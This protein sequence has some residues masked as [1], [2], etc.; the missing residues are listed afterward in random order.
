[1]KKLD[2]KNFDKSCVD[3]YYDK[4]I[5][6]VFDLFEET[7]DEVIVIPN[8]K[9]QTVVSSS[10][11]LNVM[12]EAGITELEME[13]FN[14]VDEDVES[15]NVVVI[16]QQLVRDKKRLELRSKI[17]NDMDQYKA[18]CKNIIMS[19]YL[20]E[21]GN[22]FYKATVKSNKLETIRVQ[23]DALYVSK[24]FDVTKW[25]MKNEKKY[26]ELALGAN[27]ILGKPTHNAFQER[28][29]SRGT[30]SDTKLRK[31]L[32]E[33]YFE[34]SVLNS[35]NGKHIDDI[36]HMMQPSIMLKEK[37]RQKELKIFME[38]RKCEL[39]MTNI[40]DDGVVEKPPLYGSVCSQQ[41][42]SEMLDD[43]DD[44]DISFG[45]TKLVVNLEDD[46]SKEV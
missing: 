43:D 33:E 46:L 38:Q 13:L 41:T 15:E 12:E 39:D 45:S 22:D 5:E 3:L 23:R 30:Y 29:F 6:F 8:K 16:N 40:I 26:P 42:D 21:Y 7:I 34:M 1:L 32:K 19:D 9:Q 35:V 36:Y 31:R 4:A 18:Y 25:W 20:E 14:D 2:A 17:K 37:D 10:A 28:V 27:V 44:D 24:F 11:R